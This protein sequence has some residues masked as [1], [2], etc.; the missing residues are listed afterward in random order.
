MSA[1]SIVA[2]HDNFFSPRNL[3]IAPGDTVKWVQDGNSPHT[4]TS[5]TGLWDSGLLGPGATFSV[6]FSNAGTFPYFCEVHGP[7]MSGS[8]IVGSGGGGPARDLFLL[9]F[10]GSSRTTNALGKAAVSPERSKDFINDCAGEQQRNPLSLALVYDLQADAIVVVDINNGSNVCTV[11]TFAGG[12]T[13]ATTD[14]KR[15]DRQ[16]FVFWEDSEMASGSMAA[17]E[18]SSRGTSG[19]LLK[20]SLRGSIQLGLEAYEDEPPRVIQ[21]SFSTGRRFVPRM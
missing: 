15:K 20:Y 3:N 17:T 5:T 9:N 8:I 7:A 6:T 4:T 11:A 18:L 2:I 21:A 19:E 1:E 12:V 14:G 10:N 16:A 13:V